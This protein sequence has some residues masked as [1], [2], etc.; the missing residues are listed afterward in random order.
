MR[1]C[2]Y[3][4]LLP[5]QLLLILEEPVGVGISAPTG[6]FIGGHPQLQKEVYADLAL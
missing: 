3:K 1:P 6:A 4:Y 2:P 5:S